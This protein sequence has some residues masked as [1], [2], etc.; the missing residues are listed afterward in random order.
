MLRE[1]GTTHLPLQL[2]N[3]QSEDQKCHLR[4]GL[5][6][7]HNLMSEVVERY[8]NHQVNDIGQVQLKKFPHFS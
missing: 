5:L 7:R 1:I 4:S 8:L 3:D 2:Y 6:I